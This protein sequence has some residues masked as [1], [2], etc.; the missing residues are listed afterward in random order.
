M[1]LNAEILD[2]VGTDKGKIT[3]IS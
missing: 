2:K 3:S 1:S